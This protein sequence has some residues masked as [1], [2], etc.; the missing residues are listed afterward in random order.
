MHMTS[1]WMDAVSIKGS[2]DLVASYSKSGDLQGILVYHRRTILGINVILMPPMCFYNGIKI[3]YPDRLS[4][5]EKVSLEE[6]VISDLITQLPPYSFYYQQYDPGFTN[7]APLYWRGFKQ[8]TRYTYRL[9]TSLEGKISIDQLKG[10]LRRNIQKAEAQCSITETTLDDFISALIDA[11][12]GRKNP[13]NIALIKRLYSSLE[14][15]NAVRLIGCRHLETN[16]MLAG[17]MIAYDKET[18]YYVAGF[19]NPKYKDSGALSYLLWNIISSN[20]T[21]CFDFEGSMIKEIEHF[22]RGFGG[23]WTPHSRIWKFNN[24]ILAPLLKYKFRSLIH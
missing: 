13:F 1:A 22:F 10:N 12:A 16:V 3:F 11:Y 18:S 14:R 5:Y 23:E 15:K 24:P 8:T 7:W 2:W 17:A 19:Y 6:K 9:N 20:K 21:P 4:Q